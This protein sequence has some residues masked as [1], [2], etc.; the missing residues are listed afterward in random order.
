MSRPRQT[1]HIRIYPDTKLKLFNLKREVSLAQNEDVRIPE[2]LKRIT[3]ITNLKQVL[4][5]DAKMKARF[6]FNV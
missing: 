5:D 2:I 6:K 3:N 1:T 4:F